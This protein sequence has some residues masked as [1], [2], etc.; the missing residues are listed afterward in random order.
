MFASDHVRTLIFQS[1]GTTF[2]ARRNGGLWQESWL[3]K[4]RIETSTLSSSLTV[5]DWK[6]RNRIFQQEQL[7]KQSF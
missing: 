1:Q 3:L 5:G 7:D 2:T 6:G 4:I